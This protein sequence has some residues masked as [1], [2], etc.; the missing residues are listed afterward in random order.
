LIPGLKSL[1]RGAGPGT[2]I[3]LLADPPP[4]PHG[5]IHVGILLQEELQDYLDILLWG[6]YLVNGILACVDKPDKL[7][8]IIWKAPGYLDILL[9][10]GYLLT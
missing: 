2:Q 3:F 1:R 7:N 5:K 6:S 9:C 4:P 8:T 10:D